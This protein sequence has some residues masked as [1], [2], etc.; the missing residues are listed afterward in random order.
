MW[1]RIDREE[2]E[3]LLHVVWDPVRNLLRRRS[4]IYGMKDAKLTLLLLLAGLSQNLMFDFL[5]LV[6]TLSLYMFNFCI[7]SILMYTKYIHTSVL[8]FVEAANVVNPK[9]AF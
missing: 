5:C 2:L 6:N 3:G 4:A 9:T 8:C 1:W 7:L